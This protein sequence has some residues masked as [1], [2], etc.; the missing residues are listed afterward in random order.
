MDLLSVVRSHTALEIVATEAA[1]VEVAN[2]LST[3]LL[4]WKRRRI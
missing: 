1:V 3:A 2:E 4:A